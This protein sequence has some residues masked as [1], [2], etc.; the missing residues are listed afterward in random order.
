MTKLLVRLSSDLHLEAFYGRDPASLV[1]DFLPP[2]PR[3]SEAVL[4]LAGD[5]SSVPDQLLGFLHTVESRFK[6]V[7]FIPGNHSYYRHD[8]A[9]WNKTMDDRFLE[10]L[11]NTIWA[12]GRVGMTI[13]ENI[14]FIMC[15]LWGDGGATVAEQIRV[16]HGLNDFRIIRNGVERFKVQDMMALHKAQKAELVRLLKVP[17]DGKTV[18]CTHHMPSYRLCHPRFGTE[19][20]GGFASNCDDILAYDHAPDLWFAGHTHD[21]ID[22]QLWKTRIVINPAGY[23]GEWHSP[24]NTYHL[25]P[26][27]IEV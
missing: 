1:P 22:T 16:D 27:F 26:K 12:N 5:I 25:G 13:F 24:Y 8:Y 4:V 11:K 3:D 15:T 9:A 18:V 20:N 14:R 21:T 6:K 23:R 10:T 17:F 19:I 2:D 7:F